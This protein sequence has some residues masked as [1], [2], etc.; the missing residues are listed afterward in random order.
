MI[1]TMLL[2]GAT[3]DLAG[4]FLLPALARLQASGHIPDDFRVVG[5]ARED[6][7][8]AAFQHH[9]S[10]Q[11]EEHAGDIGGEVRRTFVR[12]WLE[13]PAGSAGPTHP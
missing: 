12:C 10:L 13:Y 4:R 5:A 8:D 7:G 9:A 3:G 11:L 2:F 6:W 1:A